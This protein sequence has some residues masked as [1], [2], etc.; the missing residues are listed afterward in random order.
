ML[1]RFRR[2]CTLLFVVMTPGCT[3]LHTDLQDAN[4][5]WTQSCRASGFGLL[6]GLIAHASY[7]NCMD[8]ARAFGLK[9][10]N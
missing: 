1:K 4:G 5:R 9:P 10:I 3:D 2:F 6:T 7:N 8:E